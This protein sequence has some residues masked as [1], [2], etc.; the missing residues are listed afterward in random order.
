LVYDRTSGTPSCTLCMIPLSSAHNATITG[1]SLVVITVSSSWLSSL[2]VRARRA[3]GDSSMQFSISCTDPLT[4]MTLFAADPLPSLSLMYQPSVIRAIRHLLLVATSGTS[5]DVDLIMSYYD[6]TPQSSCAWSDV[7]R[8]FIQQPR[9]SLIAGFT[10]VITLPRH[11]PAV[12][13][14]RLPIQVDG[15]GFDGVDDR[16]LSCF[17]HWSGTQHGASHSRLNTNTGEGAWCSGGGGADELHYVQVNYERPVTIMAVLTQGR[18]ASHSPQWIEEYQLLY[19]DNR[20]DWRRAHAHD[21]KGNIDQFSIAF[22]RVHPAI[23]AQ[24]WRLRAT[25]W[26]THPATRWHLQM[27]PNG[28]DEK[29][30]CHTL[31]RSLLGHDISAYSLTQIAIDNT[32]EWKTA[33]VTTLPS[34]DVTFVWSGGFTGDLKGGIGVEGSDKDNS[35][36]GFALC[37]NDMMVLQFG[38]TH[39]PHQWGHPSSLMLTWSVTRTGAS[40]H[41]HSVGLFMLWIHS[42]MRSQLRI[43]HGDTVRLSVRSLSTSGQSF[44]IDPIQFTTSVCDT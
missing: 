15:R 44:M 38:V 17:T 34:M 13:T 12:D 20:F 18:A 14:S 6:D 3:T 40:P 32:L 39:Q 10:D 25:K 26:H 8:W 22:N 33:P 23:T 16:Q 5:Y 2:P 24:Y 4:Q 29:E 27:V 37:I 35:G 31:H 9:S 28:D 11:V 41:Y 43:K 1:I 19:S 36:D 7:R 42:S 30:S 21:L